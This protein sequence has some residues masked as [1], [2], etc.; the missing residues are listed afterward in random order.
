MWHPGPAVGS[1]VSIDLRTPT[2]LTANDA[3]DVDNLV[4]P[5]LDAMSGVF[6]VRRRQ[7]VSQAD[8]ERVVGT[9]R[10]EASG[11]TRRK[12]RAHRSRFG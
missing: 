4:K 6:G 11:P 8:D 1:P 3:W 10:H 2:P 12:L 7:G 5:T 9:P